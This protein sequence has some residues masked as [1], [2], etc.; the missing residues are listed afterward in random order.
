MPSELNQLYE[1]I[2][3]SKIAMMT[4]RGADGLLRSRPMAN[5]KQA[6]GAD[7][8]FVTSE[9]TAKLEDIAYHP[10]VNL[11]YFREGKMEWVSVSGIATLSRDRQIIHELYAPDW[12]VWF[13]EEGDARHGTPD[14]PRMVLIGID[15]HLA[16]FLEVNKPK[17]LLLFEIAK[18]WITGTE[19]NLGEMHKLE[20]PHRR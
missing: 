4:T 15:V 19:P 8:W 10:H 12:Q 5:Q 13:A 1:M 7:L 9:G 14:D 16:E 2:E 18:G 3:D 17:P 11:S 6:R 20:G